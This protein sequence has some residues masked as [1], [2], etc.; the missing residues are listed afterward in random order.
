VQHCD[1]N[2]EKY[3]KFISFFQVMKHRLKETDKGK[4]I[5]SEKNPVPKPLCPP[6][7]PHG[8]T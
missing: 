6:K 3:D 4:Q 1:E 2:K 8:L 5:Y 7:I